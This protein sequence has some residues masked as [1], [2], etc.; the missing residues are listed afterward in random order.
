MTQILNGPKIDAANGKAHNLV[1]LCHGYGAN[2]ADLIGLAQLWQNLLPDTA[3]LAPNAPH[4]CD[5]GGFGY[6]W[7]PI[8]RD[9]P[10]L[11]RQHIEDASSLLNLFITTHLEE[12][13]LEVQNLALVGFSQGTMMSLYIG[14]RQKVAPAAILGFSGA[15][16]GTD[17]LDQ[18]TIKPPILLIHGAQDDM[19]AP[20]ATISAD[21][22]LND[23]GFESHHHIIPNCGHTIAPDGVELGGRF[24]VEHIG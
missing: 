20:Q 2:G 1:I 10:A 8:I 19:I 9:N 6:Q 24:L 4:K 15:L 18:I 23:K 12:H 7:F 16:V 3:F 13:G 5:M 22:A 17:E 14:L 21:K 11:L